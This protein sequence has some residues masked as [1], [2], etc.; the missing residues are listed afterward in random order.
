M[1]LVT[2]SNKM[3]EWAR[4]E[5]LIVIASAAWQSHTTIEKNKKCHC[6]QQ[7]EQVGS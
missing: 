5:C 6:A 4:K 3:N 2:A 1:F 7:D